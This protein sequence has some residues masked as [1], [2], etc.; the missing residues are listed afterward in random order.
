MFAWRK[1]SYC[2]RLQARLRGRMKPLVEFRNSSSINWV[3]R[4]SLIRISP[5]VAEVDPTIPRTLV[6]SVAGVGPMEGRCFVMESYGA[7]LLIC[8]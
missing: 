2:I 5:P 4:F 6:E 7:R 3:S 1:L 8:Y